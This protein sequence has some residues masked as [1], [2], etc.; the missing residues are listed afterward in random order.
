[1]EKEIKESTE[2]FEC[3]NGICHISYGR[4][5]EDFTNEETAIKRFDEL[6]K[7]RTRDS[8]TSLGDIASILANYDRRLD[9]ILPTEGQKESV[10]AT[11]TPD[12]N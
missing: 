12:S 6:G 9:R 8:N 5:R 10:Y 7:R 3:I 1:M 2:I 4:W 11:T